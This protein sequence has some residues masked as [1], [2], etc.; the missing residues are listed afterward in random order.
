MS[1]PDVL[2]SCGQYGRVLE[3][4]E[5][6]LVGIGGPCN[7]ISQ[8][9]TVDSYSANEFELLGQLMNG[10]SDN[11]CGSAIITTSFTTLLLLL[12]IALYM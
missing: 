11:V 6:Y 8:W 5:H 10:T 12:L 9:S 7:P 3:I 4:G 2:T 1:G